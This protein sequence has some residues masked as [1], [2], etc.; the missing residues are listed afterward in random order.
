MSGGTNH[1]SR[2]PAPPAPPKGARRALGAGRSVPSLVD[3]ARAARLQAAAAQVP[4]A[5][6]LMFGSWP[7][8]QS[9][10]SFAPTSASTP[11]RSA[12]NTLRA[13]VTASLVSL[14][15]GALI[16]LGL[17]YL[18]AERANATARAEPAP[19][20]SPARQA[21]SAAEPSRAAAA[22]RAAESTPREA[23]TA[24]AV[25][26][27]APAGPRSPER[28]VDAVK[29]AVKTEPARSERPQ[30]ADQA[31]G[32]AAPVKS[33]PAPSEAAIAYPDEPARAPFNRDAAAKALS[34]ARAR[35]VACGDGKT[36]GLARIAVSF[37][38]SGRA[39]RA[40]LE[41]DSELLGTPAGSCIAQQMRSASVPPFDGNLV[42]VHTSV[43]LQGPEQ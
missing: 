2:P 3:L 34:E 42:T 1:R 12:A 26:A 11:P 40:V 24:S 6:Q 32:A 9:T 4:A 17:Q 18:D 35:A 37:A 5:N 43:R 15:V 14:V 23:H 36:A 27:V 31:Q 39:T 20:P 10:P 30:G 38:P 21:R 13:A 29:D 28:V 16:T 8:P 19:T 25:A 7:S 41:G 33:E 22:T